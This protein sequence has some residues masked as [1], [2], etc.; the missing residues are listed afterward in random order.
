MLWKTELLEHPQVVAAV[1]DPV[2]DDHLRPLDP[3]D[4]QHPRVWLAGQEV[5]L[6]AKR[7]YRWVHF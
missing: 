1:V 2:P 7:K 3:G 6:G 5:P 4:P